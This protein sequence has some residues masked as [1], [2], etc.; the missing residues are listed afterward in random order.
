[1]K[2]QRQH[3]SLLNAS[4]W[5]VLIVVIKETIFFNTNY[6]VVVGSSTAQR[7]ARRAHGSLTMQPT[8][9]AFEVLLCFI[10]L[11]TITRKPD[12]SERKSLLLKRR[13][14]T[15]LYVVFGTWRVPSLVPSVI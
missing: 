3:L 4:Q 7:T 9:A 1:M 5:T 14:S 10:H 8:A 11:D 13:I 6:R 15:T 2:P 12:T